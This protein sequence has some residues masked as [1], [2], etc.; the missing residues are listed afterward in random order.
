MHTSACKKNEASQWV[1]KAEIKKLWAPGWESDTVRSADLVFD[2]ISTEMVSCSQCDKTS[3][4]TEL[5]PVVCVHI[6]LRV[7]LPRG[8]IYRSLDFFLRGG[9]Q[10]ALQMAVMPQL[11]AAAHWYILLSMCEKCGQADGLMAQWM[12][13]R[14]K[15]RREK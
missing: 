11:D 9:D 3:D 14:C 1:I 10:L 5:G 7:C 4:F 13:N 15:Y 8:Q 2:G 6:S 12:H